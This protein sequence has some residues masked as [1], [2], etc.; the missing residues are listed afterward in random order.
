MPAPKHRPP[1]IAGE[2]CGEAAHCPPLRK[3]R[4]RKPRNLAT[5]G[6]VPANSTPPTF[7]DDFVLPKTEALAAALQI[8]QKRQTNGA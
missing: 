6:P 7:D 5:G 1:C 2:V 8:A 3:P 4:A